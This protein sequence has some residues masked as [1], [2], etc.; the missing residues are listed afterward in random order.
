METT[1][2]T[3][4]EN[5]AE[6]HME[7]CHSTRQNSSG[8]SENTCR[9]SAGGLYVS[10]LPQKTTVASFT[11]GSWCSLIHLQTGNSFKTLCFQECKTEIVTEWTPILCLI[12]AATGSE[13]IPMRSIYK[14]DFFFCHNVPATSEDYV[15]SVDNYSE[16]ALVVHYISS[17]FSVY[18]ALCCKK[19]THKHQHQF[20][21]LLLIIL[22]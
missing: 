20:W 12:V 1:Q 14:L 6:T 11:A 10:V 16:V 22:E 18:S 21:F 8:T 17:N 13:I 5:W 3:I 19:T 2:G 9:V 7:T 15:T 4:L